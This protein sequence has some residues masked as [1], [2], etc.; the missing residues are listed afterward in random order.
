MAGETYTKRHAGGFVD[1]IDTTK[2]DSQFL[3]AV[4]AAL[5]RL[6]GED[7]ATDEVPSWT[8]GSDR[9]VFQK[10]V[11]A[12]IDAAAAIAKSK[13]AALNITN[14]DVDAAAAIAKSKLAALDITNSDV[15]VA[16]AIAYSKLALAG[17]IVNADIS[18]SAAIAVSKLA[19]GSN[20]QVLTTTA[21]AAAWGAASGGVGLGLVVALGG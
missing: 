11:N 9:F 17:A 4:E 18:A 6:L 5:L 2:V 16:A 12:N 3:N 7:P 14:S 13:L 10:I 1:D 15:N 20:G 19:A 21:G 8:P